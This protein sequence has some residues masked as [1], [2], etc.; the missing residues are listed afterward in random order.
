MFANKALSNTKQITMNNELTTNVQN[1]L[2]TAATHA[3]NAHSKSTNR[4]YKNDLQLLQSYATQNGIA[5]MDNNL[6]IVAQIT[7]AFVCGFLGNLITN[8]YT[9]T[10][11]TPEQYKP[12]TLNRLL[13]TI[14]AASK[15]AGFDTPV[16]KA[17]RLIVSGYSKTLTNNTPYEQK[18]AAALKNYE[19]VKAIYTGTFGDCNNRCTR[20]KAIV[21][22]GFAACLRRNEI[23]QLKFADLNF[24]TEK[25]P[26]VLIKIK[27]AKTGNYIKFI[28]KG[29][30][31]DTCPVVALQKWI[32]KGQI[33]KDDFLFPTIIKGDKIDKAQ[34]IAGQ[35]VQRI[36]QKYFNE[37]DKTYTGHSL[38]VGFAVSAKIKG[39]S[40]NDIQIAGAWKSATMVNR[41]AEQAGAEEAGI[42][43]F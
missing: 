7:P 4:A 15:S 39:A 24:K 40:I 26:G 14:G 6:N 20:D 38:R 43:L 27:N 32:A 8:G 36:L 9:K 41:Y 21:L 1:N 30:D 10:N 17:V 29:N 12:A 13:A 16:N 18:Q 19:I 37:K 34:H 5:V 23:A 33:T 31:P 11:G 35:T 42:E 28:P 2:L 3:A 22:V 25:R